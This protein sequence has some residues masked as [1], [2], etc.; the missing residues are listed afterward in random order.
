MAFE[1]IREV[2]EEKYFNDFFPFRNKIRDDYTPTEE[3]IQEASRLTISQ[4]NKNQEKLHAIAK[5][6]YKDKSGN[7][8]SDELAT[9]KKLI[10]KAIAFNRW[11]LRMD[12]LRS[13]GL[14]IPAPREKVATPTPA[15]TPPK[16][17]PAPE[18]APEPK[19]KTKFSPAEIREIMAKKKQPQRVQIEEEPMFF[20]MNKPSLVATPKRAFQPINIRRDGSV[21]NDLYASLF[22]NIQNKLEI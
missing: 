6:V 5:K 2:G 10:E 11:Q 16:K 8:T 18:P 12:E 15:P 19:K 17:E 9:M 3:D 20:K 13:K 1:P 7:A 21:S 14:P 4:Y 22:S